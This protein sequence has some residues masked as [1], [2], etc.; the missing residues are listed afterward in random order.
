MY[1]VFKYLWDKIIWLKK[2]IDIKEENRNI[3]FECEGNILHRC[4]FCK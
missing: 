4:T 2:S 1:Y 3:D